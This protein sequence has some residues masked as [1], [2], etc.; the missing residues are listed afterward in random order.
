MADER[1][2]EHEPQVLQ[3]EDDIPRQPTSQ[4]D[5]FIPEPGP[6]PGERKAFRVLPFALIA[7]AIVVAIV[8]V[9][10]AR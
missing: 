8:I 6:R 1:E 5:P 2:V 9:A 3:G 4:R 7:I 10:A